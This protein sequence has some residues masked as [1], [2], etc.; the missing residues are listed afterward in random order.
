M[1]QESC[2]SVEIIKLNFLLQM[3]LKKTSKFRI[4]SLTV[5]PVTESSGLLEAKKT[6]AFENEAVDT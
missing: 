4:T 3:T 2:V 5:G 6:K 1:R